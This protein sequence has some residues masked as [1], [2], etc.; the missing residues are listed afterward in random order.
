MVLLLERLRCKVLVI[1]GQCSGRKGRYNDFTI[2]TFRITRKSFR[3][4]YQ[5]VPLADGWQFGFNLI[6]KIFVT[7]TEKLARLGPGPASN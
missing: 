4:I 3:Y 5:F 2:I 7:T 1:K 6:C